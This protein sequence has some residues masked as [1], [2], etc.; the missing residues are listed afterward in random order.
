MLKEIAKTILPLFNDHN[1]KPKIT[2]PKVI[3][4]TP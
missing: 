2:I 3:T 1:I 4:I